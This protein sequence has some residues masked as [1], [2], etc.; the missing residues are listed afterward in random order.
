MRIVSR[1]RPVVFF[2]QEIWTYTSLPSSIT[3][4][5][6]HDAIT[7]RVIH[8]KAWAVVTLPD[9]R[10]RFLVLATLASMS[11]SIQSFQTIPA[12]QN[13]YAARTQNSVWRSMNRGEGAICSC[14]VSA[15]PANKADHAVSTL[16]AR[17]GIACCRMRK[18]A[19]C[20]SCKCR[21]VF[22]KA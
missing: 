5:T 7:C 1:A 12:P 4:R 13:R 17:V 20:K 14:R 3:W 15:A 16:L 8:T 9:A 19:S 21:V 11:R 22:V 2:P 10:G 18:P 6:A